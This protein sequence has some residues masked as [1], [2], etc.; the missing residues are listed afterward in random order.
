MTFTTTSTLDVEHV[1]VSFILIERSKAGLLNTAVEPESYE[2]GEHYIAQLKSGEQQHTA[3]LKAP[4]VVMPDGDYIIVAYVDTAGVIK[5]E[6]DTSDNVSRG[7]DEGEEVT[8]GSVSIVNG[9][10]NDFVLEK[11]AVGDGFALFPGPGLKSTTNAGAPLETRPDLIGF[12]NASKFG[13]S[14]DTVDVSAVMTIGGV[15]YPAHLWHKVEQR[16]VDRMRVLFPPSEQSH[17]FPWDIAINGT[18]LQAIHDDFDP[19]ATENTLKLTLSLQ[20][21]SGAIEASLANNTI[22]IDVPYALFTDEPVA[23]TTTAPKGSIS[24]AAKVST[25]ARTGCTTT[26][27]GGVG[28]LTDCG[29]YVNLWSSYGWTLGDT[30]KVAIEPSIDMNVVVGNGWGGRAASNAT[31]GF[32]IHMFDASTTLIEGGVS[33]VSIAADAEFTYWAG[34]DVLGVSIMNEGDTVSAFSSDWTAFEWSESILLFDATFTVGIVPVA[35]ESGVEGSISS[36]P[37]LG[38]QSLVISAG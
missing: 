4:N 3:T 35:V 23:G 24:T 38:F 25:A 33:A 16:Y 19:N 17:Y 36:N 34:L 26:E 20:D 13:S 18:L 27:A 29:S 8:Y 31:V 15:D 12:F 28:Y 30:S 6:V 11:V 7:F 32:D 1:G 2:A 37:A 14:G 5:N 22:S 10:Y 21:T 9:D